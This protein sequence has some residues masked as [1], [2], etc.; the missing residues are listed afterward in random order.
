MPLSSTL[1]KFHLST[2]PE[3]G[4]V[5]RDTGQISRTEILIKN[6]HTDFPSGPGIKNLSANAEDTGSIPSL[7]RFHMLWGKKPMYHN[8]WNP[9]A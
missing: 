1:S 8:F 3:E 6:W 4:G 9:Y 5:S 2:F 7:G